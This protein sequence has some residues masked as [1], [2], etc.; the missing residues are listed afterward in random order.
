MKRFLA[1]IILTIVF[2][3]ILR[4]TFSNYMVDAQ[5]YGQ[6]NSFVARANTPSGVFFNPAGLTQLEKG[7]VTLGLTPLF[8][9]T[10][11]DTPTGTD[12]DSSNPPLIIPNLYTAIPFMDGKIVAGFGVNSPHVMGAEW[13][14]LAAFRYF[15][16]QGE[17][18]AL[19]LTPTLSYKIH[20][21]I[22]VGAGVVYS[23]I[24]GKVK[25]FFPQTRT[26]TNIVIVGVTPTLVVTQSTINDGLRD[27]TGSGDGW[28]Y[29]LGVH[30]TPFENHS[31]GINYRSRIMST[32][33]GRTEL[34]SMAGDTLLVFPNS[35]YSVDTETDLNLPQSFQFGY[36]Y[37]PEKWAVE[38]D[39]LWVDY[40][41]FGENYFSAHT[42]SNAARQLVL[43]PS[44]P[45]KR[46]WQSSWRFSLGGNY[47]LTDDLEL[48][49]GYAYTS[50]VVPDHTFEPGIPDSSQH[51]FTTGAGYSFWKLTL[52]F[53]YGYVYIPS[54]DVN[55][56]TS[57]A[58]TGTYS[59][60][61]H[62]LSSSLTYHF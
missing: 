27:F 51:S 23:Y 6:A 4:A 18:M 9:R 34:K 10:N 20:D 48:R 44:N 41:S 47:K 53:A 61:E 52:D 54:R 26:T 8:S 17:I 21:K 38:V 32:I 39:A 46:N 42:E 59:T 31:I 22:S 14:N 35:H 49:G 12:H 40:T 50:E 13:T 25:S 5:A 43:F 37:A 3:S 30:I 7:A 16:S 36:A 56:G 33:N 58:L 60:K 45:I 29:N 2:P 1:V 19:Q 24:K 15:T 28:G 11:Y 55:Y 62:I 57:S